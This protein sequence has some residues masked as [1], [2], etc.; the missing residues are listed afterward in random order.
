MLLFN[1]L[2][3]IGRYYAEL[4]GVFKL[5][6][7]KRQ[8]LI[9]EMI[10]VSGEVSSKELAEKFGVSTMT[11][12]RDLN[13]L[14]K[15][16]KINLIYGG[17][18]YK[19]GSNFENPMSVKELENI[20]EKKNIGKYCNRIIKPSSSVF[21]E[22]GTTTLAVAKE[23]FNIRN[24]AFYTNSLLVMNTLSKYDEVNLQSVP[25]QYRDLSKGFLGI[26]TCE[27]VQNFNF[28]YCVIGTE[29]IS[30]TSGVTLLDK[31]DTY[32]KRAVMKQSKCKILV[33]D[34]GKFK[35]NYLYKI[36][37]VCDFDYIITDN[38][39]DKKIYEDIR[40]ITKIVSVNDINN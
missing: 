21:I 20:N 17:A 38:K 35:K 13:E 3:F 16:G 34:S 10:K 33:A 39:I 30:V 6:Q 11:I 4:R 19:D 2:Y 25:G 1:L 24:C 23:I 7:N 28:D 32:T 12:N 36:G 40:E 37:E 26:Q 15:E 8:K 29:G 5:K 22:T 18:I 9:L 27:Y 31:D 14:A